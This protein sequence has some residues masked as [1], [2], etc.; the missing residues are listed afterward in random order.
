MVVLFIDMK[1]AF[2]SVDREVLVRAMR[3]KGVRE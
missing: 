2:D 3:G 1:A